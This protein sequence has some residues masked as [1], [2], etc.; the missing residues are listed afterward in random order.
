MGFNAWVTHVI[1][2]CV[3]EENFDS[4]SLTALGGRQTVFLDKQQL[5]RFAEA[6]D[7]PADRIRQFEDSE[8]IDT[9]T[10]RTRNGVPDHAYISLMTGT[11]TTTFDVTDYENADATLDLNIPFSQQAS[12]EFLYNCSFVYDGGCLD[13][14]FDPATALKNLV[15]LLKPNGRIVNWAAASNWPGAYAMISPEW[16]FSFYALNGFKNIRVYLFLPFDDGS[17]KWPNL[18]ASVFRYSP[19]FTRAEG[20]DP[21]KAALSHP[22]HPAFVLATAELEFPGQLDGWKTPIQSHYLTKDHFDWRLVSNDTPD[23]PFVFVDN[24]NDNE[25][26]RRPFNSDHY[27][28][29]GTLATMPH[30]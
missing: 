1:G 9:E 27:R 26:I 7:I 15:S 28:F 16:L 19:I 8:L 22:G 12:K 23:L 17:S 18:K 25:A 30:S 2:A 6:Y 5:K 24:Q 10:L 29:I 11:S 13:N 4:Y 14:V 3:R 21:W 20:W